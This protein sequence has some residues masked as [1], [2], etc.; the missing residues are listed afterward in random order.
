MAA[1]DKTPYD[2]MTNQELESI[3]Y[4]LNFGDDLDKPYFGRNFNIVDKLEEEN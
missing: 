2:D 3:M 1:L 4:D